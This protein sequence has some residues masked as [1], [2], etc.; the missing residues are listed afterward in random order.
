MDAAKL[1]L[2]NAIEAGDVDGQVAAQEQMARLSSRC[3]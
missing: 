2:K 3:S 1:A